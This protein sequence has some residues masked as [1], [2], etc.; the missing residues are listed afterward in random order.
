MKKIYFSAI[1]ISILTISCQTKSGDKNTAE[2]LHVELNE[3]KL[4]VKPDSPNFKEPPHLSI[5]QYDSLQINK[6]KDLK[7]YD[8]SYLSMGRTLLSNENGK[9]ITIQVITDGEITEY[10]LSYDRNG[11]LVDNLIVAYE[12][13]VEYY[14]QITS[15]INSNKV[16]IQTVN[17]SYENLKGEEVEFS[18]TSTISYSISPELKFIAD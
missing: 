18:D 10:L 11:N 5:A 15:Q 14:S 1:L 7:D 6:I 16:I 9:I 4:N 13:M 2:E 17:F 3:D 8:I 12:D